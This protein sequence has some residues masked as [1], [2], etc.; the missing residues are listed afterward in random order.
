MSCREG[1]PVSTDVK[2][3]ACKAISRT[4]MWQWKKKAAEIAAATP[5]QRRAKASK[6]SCD[7]KRYIY[8]ACLLPQGKCHGKATCPLLLKWKEKEEPMRLKQIGGGAL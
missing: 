8:T 1:T 7:G 6:A 2:G 5:E 4:M 3:K